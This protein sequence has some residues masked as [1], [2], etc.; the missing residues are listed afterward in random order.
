MSPCHTGSLFLGV[1]TYFS[2][3]RGELFWDPVRPVPFSKLPS[4]PRC[5]PS[6]SGSLNSRFTRANVEPSRALRCL[7]DT[8][9]LTG[10]QPHLAPHPRVSAA[11][12]P[13]HSG[14]CSCQHFLMLKT[15]KIESVPLFLPQLFNSEE[16][17]FSSTSKTY[18]KCPTLGIF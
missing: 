18:P 3:S 12:P 7:K 8:P 5:C 13:S 1:F 2:V 15:L 6:L 14:G 9:S 4:Y 16:N 10:P 17:A 11:L